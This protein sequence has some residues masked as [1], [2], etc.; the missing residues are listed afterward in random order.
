ML[1][2]VCLFSFCFRCDCASP[3]DVGRDSHRPWDGRPHPG[4]GLDPPTPR[5]GNPCRKY[6]GPKIPKAQGLLLLCLLMP[7]RLFRFL[8]GD[9]YGKGKLPHGLRS[10]G[11]ARAPARAR[12]AAI[13]A[14]PRSIAALTPADHTGLA[15]VPL[16]LFRSSLTFC[17]MT[18][19]RADLHPVEQCIG[20]DAFR[21]AVDRAA[22]RRQHCVPLVRLEH[23]CGLI[24]T[25]D[26]PV[27]QLHCP[28]V[29]T[30]PRE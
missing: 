24:S 12:R 5:A 11:N 19:I 15:L 8:A 3:R 29:G 10:R 4:H 16:C 30:I 13:N 26:K 27:H 9:H 1:Q 18:G 7:H 21:A 2:R 14:A 28:P 22:D 23:V 6:I 20:T 25:G 17:R